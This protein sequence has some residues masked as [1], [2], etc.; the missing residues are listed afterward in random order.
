MRSSLW[1]INTLLSAAQTLFITRVLGF[2]CCGVKVLSVNLD[3]GFTGDII[4]VLVCPI[5]S[6]VCLRDVKVSKTDSLYS[7]V[8]FFS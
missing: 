1:C 2:I 8:I 6:N 4:S 3:R 7:G 5:N